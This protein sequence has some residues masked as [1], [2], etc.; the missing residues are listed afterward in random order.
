[1]PGDVIL[2]LLG[3]ALVTYATRAGG[4][5]LMSRIPHSP[6][7]ERWLQYLPGAVLVAIIAPTLFSTGPAEILAAAALSLRNT[8]RCF[9]NSVAQSRRAD[10]VMTME[11]QFST[12]NER[13]SALLEYMQEIS[14]LNGLHEL[15]LFWDQHTALPET[16]QRNTR[17]TVGDAAPPAE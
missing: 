11:P 8:G 6:A 13:I 1:M 2:T 17:R 15:A 10:T 16:G 5:W 9:L 12:N 7:V 14:D 3:M 4:H